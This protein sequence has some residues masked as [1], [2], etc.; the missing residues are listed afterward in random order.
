[1][2]S[3]DPRLIRKLFRGRNSLSALI[4]LLLVGIAAWLD[5]NNGPGGSQLCGENRGQCINVVDG[6]TI[7]VRGDDGTEFRIRLL[8]IDCM[9]THNEDKL[10]EQASR[11]HR[12]STEIRRLG[13]R[14]M[15]RTRDLALNMPLVWVVPEG[16]PE[17]DPYGRILAY[18]EVEKDDVAEILLREGLAELRREHHPREQHYRSIATPIY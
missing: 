13:E 8:G 3:I 11:L 14:A 18:V 5:Q 10:A 1:M 2:P 9:E 4:I 12:S 17:K 6:D 16:T 15:E 7:D